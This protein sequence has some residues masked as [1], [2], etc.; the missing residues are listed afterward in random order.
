MMFGWFGGG[1]WLWGLVLVGVV[2][3]VVLVVRVVAARAG[4]PGVTGRSAARRL[5]DERFARGELTTEEYEE[6][7]RALS[8]ASS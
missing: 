5:L 2:L 8:E 3:L 6:R 7:V 4:R 1:W